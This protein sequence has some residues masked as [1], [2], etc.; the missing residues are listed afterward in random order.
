MGPRRG[1]HVVRML[2]RRGDLKFGGVDIGRR[3][4]QLSECLIGDLMPPMGSGESGAHL[5]NVFP[6]DTVG[7]PHHCGRHARTRVTATRSRAVSEHVPL[8]NRPLGDRHVADT[9]GAGA[10]R[11]ADRADGYRAARH[12]D[13][14]RDAVARGQQQPVSVFG[15]DDGLPTTGQ[16]TVAK[17]PSVNSIA[18]GDQRMWICAPYLVGR[19]AVESRNLVGSRIEHRGQPTERPVER[20][21]LG[22]RRDELVGP[23]FKPAVSSRL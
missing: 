19:I 3:P 17:N 20:G 23:Q 5:V 1:G 13:A 16:P 11:A 21:H 4:G 9:R 2:E 14:T 15:A 10:G 7:R 22:H 6:P 18:R 12:Q 8:I